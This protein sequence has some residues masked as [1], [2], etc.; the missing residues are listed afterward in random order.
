[1]YMVYELKEYTFTPFKY[2]GKRT[3][4]ANPPGIPRRGSS[5]PGP[6]RL[7]SYTR[8][9]RRSSRT[10]FAAATALLPVGSISGASSTTSSATTGAPESRRI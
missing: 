9:L 7:R 10:I 8:R 6:A 5:G 3:R 1:M 4:I 2:T